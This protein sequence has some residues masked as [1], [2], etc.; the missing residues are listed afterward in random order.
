MRKSIRDGT[1]YPL[2]IEELNKVIQPYL[3]DDFFFLNIGACDGVMG[4][5][6]YPLARK[7]HWKG[8]AVE[9]VP[10]NFEKLVENFA[11]EPQVTLVNAAISETPQLFWYV[12]EHETSLPHIVNQMG[13][14]D[15]NHLLKNLL[16]LKILAAGGPLKSSPSFLAEYAPEGY[17]EKNYEDGTSVD[18]NVEA[19][20]KSVEIPCYTVMQLLDEHGITSVDYLNIDAEGFDHIILGMVDFERIRPSIICIETTSFNDDLENSIEDD[21]EKQNYVFARRYGLYSKVFVQKR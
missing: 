8:I 21:L 10:Y 2:Q 14:L 5:P 12:D 3:H 1:N 4:D 18:P 11:S 6:V 19:Y 7:Y 13:S 20:V 16:N 17:G 15:R 9:P